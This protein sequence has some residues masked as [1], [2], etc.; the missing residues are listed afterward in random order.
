[1]RRAIGVV[2]G[3][4]INQASHL[5]QGLNIIVPCAIGNG[6]FRGVHF[7]A[8]EFF[9]RHRFVGHGFNDIG[10][11]DEHV[12]AVAHHENEIGHRRRVHITA[13]AWAQNHRDLRNDTGRNDIAAEHFAITAQG[14]DTFLNTRTARIKQADNGCAHFKR[15]ILNFIDLL[16]VSLRERATENG[17]ILGKH[18]HRAAIDRAPAGDNTVTGNFR[19]LHS[20]I[21]RAMLDEHVK[22]FERAMIH[23]QFNPLA[24]RQLAARVLRIDAHLST[25]KAG[26]GTPIV[27]LFE[28]VFHGPSVKG[29]ADR[30]PPS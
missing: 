20:E 27:E 15:H 28:N 23:Q 11:G 26:L 7:R 1:M 3:Q 25:T 24:S 18:K 21:S 6:R 10:A 2:G 9:C 12:R 17:K 4:K 13:R 14:R 16:G 8:A 19:F 5:Q 22:L 30:L 29:W